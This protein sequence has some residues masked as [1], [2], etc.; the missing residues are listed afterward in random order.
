MTQSGDLLSLPRGPS[1]PKKHN[2][3]KDC[4][5]PISLRSDRCRQCAIP[6][7]VEQ[8]M[9]VA[10]AGHAATLNPIAQASRAATLRRH[11]A[12]TTKNGWLS[13][14]HPFWADKDKYLQH[15]QP[16]LASKGSSEIS[17]ALGV[18]VSYAIHIRKGSRIPHPRHWETLAKLVGLSDDELNG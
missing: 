16:L 1:S 12:Q 9:S 14:K 17:K 11:H 5:A 8:I 15:I 10:A 7:T 3:C 4:G 18:C 6:R 2:F 13:A